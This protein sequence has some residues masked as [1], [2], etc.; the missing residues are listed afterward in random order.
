MTEAAANEDVYK[1][2]KNGVPV[3]VADREHG[4]QRTERV[5]IIDW[6]NPET[7]D[8]LVV[9][10]FTIIGTL[11]TRRPDLVGFVNGLP[12]VIIELK[13]PGVPAQ[14]A[15]SGNLTSYKSDVPQLFWYNALMIASN[16]TDSRVG[17]LTSDGNDSSSGSV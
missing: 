11:Y 16:G 7:N 17:S 4:G 8:F 3:Q 9:N 2:L 13:K 14:Q 6:Q 5:N 10:Q 15:F 1:L 12:L